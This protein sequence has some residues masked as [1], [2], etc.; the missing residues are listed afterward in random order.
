MWTAAHGAREHFP[1]AGVLVACR[2]AAS[3]SRH[4]ADPNQAGAPHQR[5]PK[6]VLRSQKREEAGPV[7]SLVWVL[8]RTNRLLPFQGAS[9]APQKRRPGAQRKDIRKP[10]SRARRLS[11]KSEVDTAAV[12]V[13]CRWRRRVLAL[14]PN[15]DTR[16]I[17]LRGQSAFLDL[18]A[19][20][21]AGLLPKP[22]SES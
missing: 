13:P 21:D 11:G 22:A 16:K 18:A 1:T 3:P 5:D 7:K 8:R 10:Q 17:Y 9:C 4:R 20:G 19:T 6:I 15:F 2:G 14:L 12:T